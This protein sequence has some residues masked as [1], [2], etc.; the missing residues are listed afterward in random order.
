MVL[1]ST[2]HWAQSRGHVPREGCLGKAKPPHLKGDSA[3]SRARCPTSQSGL[4]MSLA[5]L[6]S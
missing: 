3:W 1:L 5:F 2:L 6:L 4:A